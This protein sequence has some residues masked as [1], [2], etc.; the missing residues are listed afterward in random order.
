MAMSFIAQTSSSLQ[1]NK[2]IHP[3]GDIDSTPEM[4]GYSVDSLISNRSAAFIP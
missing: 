1:D 4:P 2:G 3:A